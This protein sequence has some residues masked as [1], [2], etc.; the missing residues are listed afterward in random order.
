VQPV[1][2][3]DLASQ[4]TEWLSLRQATL[5]ENVAN[6]NTPGYRARDIES[7]EAALDRTELGMRTTDPRHVAFAPPAAHAS[8]FRSDTTTGN[9]VK[10]ETELMKAGEVAR[11]Y[12]LGTSL[13]KTFHRMWMT[14][15]KG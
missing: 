15:L 9:D 13:M 2:L 14:S 3:F 1:Y 11:D 7:F 12:A 8:S 10:L 4:R 5:A 6:A